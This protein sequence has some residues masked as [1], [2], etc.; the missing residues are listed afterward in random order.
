MR[1]QPLLLASCIAVP[2]FGCGAAEH[3]L[4]YKG[5]ASQLE[6]PPG[7]EVE[8]GGGGASPADFATPDDGR[9]MAG[10]AGA[11]GGGGPEIAHRRVGA[12]DDRPIVQ[13]K[14]IYSASVQLVVED[15]DAVQD[16]VREL[17][18][19]HD[20][21]LASED[22]SGSKGTARTARWR[23]R[24][25]VKDFEAFLA[26]VTRLGELTSSSTTSQ[27]VTEEFYDLEARLKQKQLEEQ[28]LLKLQEEAAAIMNKDPKARMEDLLAVRRE[29]NAVRQEIERIQGRLKLLGHL[30]ELTTVTITLT[31]RKGY[32]PPTAPTFGTTIGRTFEGSISALTSFGQGIVL[33]LVALAPWLPVIALVVVLFWLVL[34]RLRRA[35]RRQPLEVREA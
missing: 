15:L 10:D 24:V 30:T 14:T 26:A 19:R 17:I 12:Q 7:S 9:S 22:V 21:Q 27:D 2:L 28:G 34:R 31:E 4:S 5:D 3:G 13:R 23:V 35:L 32:V 18:K 1:W 11:T 25:P 20:A 16:R 6:S 29:W 8:F 33:I